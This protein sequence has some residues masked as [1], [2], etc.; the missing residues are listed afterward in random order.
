MPR[1]HRRPS[2]GDSQGSGNWE[3]PRDERRK[4]GSTYDDVRT[5]CH[6]DGTISYHSVSTIQRRQHVRD[7]LTGDEA[8]LDP[9]ELVRATE[10]LR[11]HAMEE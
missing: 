9:K 10:H 4:P 3:T 5:V 7:I 6:I 8:F 11:L 2:R 1:R